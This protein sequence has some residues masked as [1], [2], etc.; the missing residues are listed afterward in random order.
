MLW[1][2]PTARDWRSE[3]SHQSEDEL[4]GTKGR[5]LSRQVL[6]TATGGGPTSGVS[7]TLNPRFVAAMMGFP[8]EWTNS[9][10]WGTPSAPHRPDSRGRCS[11]SA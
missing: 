5:P 2:T 11:C 8:T 6:T 1:P 10:R 3:S 9:E 4:Y 7:L